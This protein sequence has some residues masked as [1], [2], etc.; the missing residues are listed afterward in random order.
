M[1]VCIGVGIEVCIRVCIGVCIGGV[2][3]VPFHEFLIPNELKDPRT[4]T[5]LTAACTNSAALRTA[6]RQG[7]DYSKAPICKY[8]KTV[9]SM[10]A[11][12]I[13]KP[14]IY[15]EIPPIYH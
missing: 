4:R 11:S 15:P 6:R 13:P 8:F 14:H 5:P 12:I 7:K 9:V 1:G 2:K 10:L 3:R